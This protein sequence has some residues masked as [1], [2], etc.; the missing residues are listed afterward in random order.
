MAYPGRCGFESCARSMDDNE[1]K[2]RLSRIT[3]AMM[4]ATDAHPERGE[5]KFIIFITA[6]DTMGMATFGYD[7]LADTTADMILHMTGLMRTVGCDIR[8]VPM[9]SPENN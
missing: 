7:D 1:E 3:E 9:P 8:F 4:E 5:E 6:G 2:A